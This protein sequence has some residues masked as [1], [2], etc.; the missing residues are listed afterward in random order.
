MVLA[1]ADGRGLP[2]V[3]AGNI[4]G[5]AIATAASGFV[6]FR[7]VPRPRLRG[8]VGHIPELF[9]FG[10]FVF[11]SRGINTVTSQIG[12]T[13]LGIVSTMTSLTYFDIPTRIIH[14]GMEVFQR[15]FEQLFPLSAGLNAQGKRELL[16]RIF[17]SIIRWQILLVL[18]ILLLVLFFGRFALRFWIGED[19]A[20]NSY[21]ILIVTAVYQ[22]VSVLTGVPF[23]YALGLGRPD[24][25]T[26]FS[27]ARLVL[28]GVVIYPAVRLYGA[29]GVA[30][31]LLVGEGQGVVFV[32]FIAHQLLDLDLWAILRRDVIKMAALLLGFVGLWLAL[33][34]TVNAQPFV[35]LQ[36]GAA[37]V[38]LALYAAGTLALGVVP[39]EQGRRLLSRNFWK[40]A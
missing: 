32:F 3:M 1:A 4:L 12:G 14:V 18:P 39:L 16:V 20:Y 38:L 6:T 36:V 22:I 33:G 30:L 9:A 27:L 2:G 37:I 17:V 26:W 28:V 8:A 21:S 23:Q 31:A 35:L 29:L 15:V 19:F 24:Y 13:V 5:Q 34:D 25:P 11:L 10:K 40:T 7:L